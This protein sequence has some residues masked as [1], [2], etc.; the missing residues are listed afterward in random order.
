MKRIL[1]LAST[2]LLLTVA[3]FNEKEAIR[4]ATTRFW[5]A[6]IDGK[7]ESAY[8]MLSKR[9][10]FNIP[11]AVFEESA[12]FGMKPTLRTRELRKAWSAESSFRIEEL[13]QRGAEALTLVSFRV[14]DLNELDKRLSKEARR[15]NIY[16]KYKGNEDKLDAWFAKRMAQEIKAH[17][18]SRVSIE[19]R[20]WLVREEGQWKI[21]FGYEY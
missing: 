9:S 18:F 13:E 15:K 5:Q 20:T 6:V 16:R 2:V 1:L 11:K 10:H 17:R 7:T 3:C 19:E 21:N 12:S 4:E 8:R 14:P